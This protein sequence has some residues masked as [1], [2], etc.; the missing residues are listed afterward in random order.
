MLQVD[1]RQLHVWSKKEVTINPRPTRNDD[2]I[3]K[4]ELWYSAFDGKDWGPWQK[5]GITFAR[6]TPI[7]WEPGEGHWRIYIRTILLS[8]LSNPEPSSSTKPSSEFIIDRTPPTA[9]IVFPPSR[10]KLRGGSVVTIKW[11]ASDEHLKDA[12]V[13][14]R[15]SLDGKGTWDVI[16]ANIGNTGSYDWTVPKDMTDAGQLQILVADKAANVGVATN[17]QILVDSVNPHGRVL[18]PAITNAAEPDLDLDIAD[19][20]PAGMA[21]ARLWFSQDDGASWTEGPFIP[22]PFKTL[23]WK[24]PGDGHYRLAVVA[25]DQAGNVSDQPKGRSDDQFPMIIDTTPPVVHITPAIGIVEA[26]RVAS[27][28]REFKPGDRV[29]V[30]FTVQDVN[31]AP[32]SV[33][34]FLQ[35]DPSQPWKP[36]GTNLP[37]DAAFRFEIPAIG[38]RT[39]RIKVQAADLAGNNG[40]AIA[41]DVFV[42]DTQVEEAPVDVK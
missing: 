28:R 16:A 5:H 6:Q 10:S 9:A 21:T 7:V 24:A 29:A 37:T 15:W 39:A 35:T 33:T 19:V 26:D 8:G 11:E 34:V 3:D 13:T 25:T 2:E 18:G 23:H 12:P 20:G 17:D 42:I 27:S 1:D 36:L 40:E 32:N 31:L 30:P 14:L 38:T 41:S 22:D 4:R